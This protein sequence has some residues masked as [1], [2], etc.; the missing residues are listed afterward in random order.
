MLA[1]GGWGGGNFHVL[2]LDVCVE[3][4]EKDPF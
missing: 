4:S 3:G 1:A 2:Y